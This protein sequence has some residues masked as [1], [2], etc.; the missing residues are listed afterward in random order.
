MLVLGLGGNQTIVPEENYF[1]VR[2]RVWLRI[3]FG[4]RGQFTSGAIALEPFARKSQ[5][6]RG[7]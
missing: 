2:V 3:S 7:H 4:V 1:P 6:L 5:K